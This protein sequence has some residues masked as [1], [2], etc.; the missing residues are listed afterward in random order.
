MSSAA[1]F[2]FLARDSFH[3]SCTRW[4]A[5][6]DCAI[7]VSIGGS[8]DVAR[9]VLHV[10]LLAKLLVKLIDSSALLRRGL[11]AD[12]VNALRVRLRRL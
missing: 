6:V 3:A 9:Q 10:E 8:H 12:G 4:C 7:A 2:F 11:H 5:Q 1:A